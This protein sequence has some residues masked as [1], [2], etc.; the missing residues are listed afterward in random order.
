MIRAKTIDIKSWLTE[1]LKLPE[2]EP[3]SDSRFCYK[4]PGWI[5]R[6]RKP[7]IEKKAA[8]QWLNAFVLDDSIEPDFYI[9]RESTHDGT[10]IFVFG[11][12]QRV[13]NSVIDEIYLYSHK[14]GWTGDISLKEV[15]VTNI[16]HETTYLD[17]ISNEQHWAGQKDVMK[18]GVKLIK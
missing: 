3:Q 13:L 7:L 16:I 11:L 14:Q 5:E 2:P 12:F 1:Y 17:R 4:T 15:R 10:L 18:I 6:E 8:E 9:T